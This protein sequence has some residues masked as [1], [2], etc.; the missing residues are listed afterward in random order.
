MIRVS[1][2]DVKKYYGSHEVLKK[3]N[4][5]IHDG[6]KVGLVGRNGEG[7]STLF[8]IIAGEETV[9]EGHV[10]I[11]KDTTVGYLQQIPHYSSSDTVKHVILRAFDRVIDLSNSMRKIEDA[12]CIDIEH[13]DELME[14]YTKLQEEFEALDGYSVEENIAKVCNGLKI[15]QEMLDRQFS[16][17]SGGEKSLILLAICLLKKPQIL[18]L[19]EPTNH[20]DIPRLEWLEGFLKDYNGALIL[21]SHDRYF[22]DK[23]VTKIFEIEDGI[24]STYCGNYSY[25]LIEKAHRYELQSIEY[26]NQQKKI[27]AMQES[28]KDLMD[29]GNRGGNDG[30]HRRA[31]SIQKSLDK[32]EK[33]DKPVIKKNIS[34]DFGETDRSGKIVINAKNISKGYTTEQLFEHVDLSIRYGEKI[35]IVGKNGQG[36]TVLLKTLLGIIQPDE[37]EVIIGANVKIGYMPQE[38]KF[39]HPER[40]VIDEFRDSFI[41]SI[42]KVRS[43]LSRFLFFNDQIYKLVGSLSGGEMA[44]LRLCQLMYQDINFLVLD[45][46]TNHLDIAS[47]EMLE[48]ALSEFQ[49]T[50]LFI[51]HDRYFINKLAQRIY[52]VENHQITEYVGDYDYYRK[53]RLELY[54]E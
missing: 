17:L 7:K 5:E 26:K 13:L 27:K 24:I 32:M 10:A 18:L 15:P 4:I 48:E 19:D 6:E 54:G 40:T 20:L 22:L 3:I 30:L 41:G 16:V 43:I 37:G 49:G 23:V 14:E 21:V 8:K 35:A 1:L 47:R 28:I 33:V 34:L 25:Y 52:A 2:S 53:K 38:I 50:V 12:M 42:E 39:E 51:S 44:R 29:W 36:K 45:E 46:P 11:K 9:D 31:G